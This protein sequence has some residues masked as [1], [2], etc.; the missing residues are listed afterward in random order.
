MLYIL[1]YNCYIKSDI[2]RVMT[3][4]W[5]QMSAVIYNSIYNSY[6]TVTF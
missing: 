6:I 4:I 3:V 1:L 5:Q 2:R